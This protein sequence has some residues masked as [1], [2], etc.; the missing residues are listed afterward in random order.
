M[1]V[2]PDRWRKIQEAFQAVVDCPP[3]ERSSRLDK[4]CMGDAELRRHVGELIDADEH[5]SGFLDTGSAP[6]GSPPA[7]RVG[8][9]RVL[10][11]LGE[12]GMSEVYA[13]VR[14]DDVYAKRVAVKFFRAGLARSDLMQRFR[15][16]RQIL[17]S[18]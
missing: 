16:E 18:L 8:P 4:I 11:R 13:A 14:E 15:V 7:P 5:P 9:Y 6:G 1:A 12:G 3:G 2:T 10:H 17:A